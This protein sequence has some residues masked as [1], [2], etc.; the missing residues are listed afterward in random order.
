[1]SFI[2]GDKAVEAARTSDLPKT[3]LKVISGAKRYAEGTG[4]RLMIRKPEDLASVR[5]LIEMKL[6]N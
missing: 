4:V 2:L 1:M 6:A 3:L 5:E